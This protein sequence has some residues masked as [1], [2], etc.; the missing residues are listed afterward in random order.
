MY[1]VQLVFIQLVFI[2]P[3]CVHRLFVPVAVSSW[4]NQ[5]VYVAYDV[6]LTMLSIPISDWNYDDE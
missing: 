5:F 1:V 3:N 6:N 4:R 2:T